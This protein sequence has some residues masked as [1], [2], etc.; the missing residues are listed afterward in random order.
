MD[1]L[2]ISAFEGPS[3]ACLVRDGRV[4]AA[5]REDRFTRLLHDSGFPS[6]AIAYCLRAGK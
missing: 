4:L 5:A 1:V 3:A 6:D 2:G